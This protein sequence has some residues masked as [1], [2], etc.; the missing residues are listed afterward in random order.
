MK[1]GLE[2]ADK[3]KGAE[4]MTAD[5]QSGLRDIAYNR[6]KQHPSMIIT[7][8]S[9]IN[10]M[11]D[12]LPASIFNTVN[13]TY[14]FEVEDDATVFGEAFKRIDKLG[15]VRIPR[16]D[17]QKAGE[18]SYQHNF[19][20]ICRPQRNA[21]LSSVALDKPFNGSD[22]NYGIK[23]VDP[24]VFATNKES[25][26]LTLDF[27]YN[28]YA[29]VPY[30]FLMVPNRGS[31]HNQFLDPYKDREIIESAWRFVHDKGL[32]QGV[33][34]CFNSLGA[35]A[36]VNDLHFQGF[37]L[38]KG[39]E[40]PIEKYLSEENF[41]KKDGFYM[42]GVSFIPLGDAVNGLMDSISRINK[43]HR[44]GEKIA[45]CF[46]MT[47]KGIVFFPRKHQGDQDYFRMIGEVN[48]PDAIS[49]GFAF[50][51]LLGEILTPKEIDFKDE[52]MAK[53]VIER[54]RKTFGALELKVNLL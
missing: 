30:H 46:Y 12:Y 33:R 23:E 52:N 11:G 18:F 36:S 34:L 53:R 5:F 6:E 54:T 41:E 3:T 16:P 50:Y 7:A 9:N 35:H 42:D 19:L 47:P 31:G 48:D 26:N 43:R 32:G 2:L 28:R 45:Y 44:D 38:V 39:W 1:Q 14:G 24:E 21:R 49:T 40:L 20:R 13:Y 10:I 22:F 4:R 29:F 27:V 25:E 51:E 17:R 15:F 37:F 8:L